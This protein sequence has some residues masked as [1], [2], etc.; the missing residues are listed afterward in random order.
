M[1][2]GK[3]QP[4]LVAWLLVLALAAAFLIPAAFGKNDGVT[5]AYEETVFGQELLTVDIVMDEDDWNSLLKNAMSEEYQ[6]AT[7]VI[8]NEKYANVGIRCKGNTSLSQVASSDSD[9]YSFKIKFDEYN[10]GETCDGLSMLVLNNLMGDATYLKEYLTYDMFHYLGADAS[11]FTMARVTVN[12]E[13][14]GVYLALEQVDEN[15]LLRE[16]GSVGELYKP[17]SM[18]FGG[19]MPDMGDF[20]MPEDFDIGNFEMPEGMEFPGM[21]GFERPS[22]EKNTDNAAAPEADGETSGD[23]KRSRGGMGGGSSLNYTDDSLDSYSTIWNGAKTETTDADHER[24]VKALKNISAGNVADYMDVDNVLRY[25]AVQTFVVNLDSLTGSMA[26]NYYLYESDGKLNLIPWDYNL[27]LGGFQSGNASETINFP[28]DTPFTSSM[29][30]RQFFAA[31]LENETYLAQYHENL[32][33]LCE[34]YASTVFPQTYAAMRLLL[35]DLVASEEAD[36]T[37]FYTNEEY[38]EAVEML[39]TTI[40]LRAESILGQL[41]GTIP[42]TT[43]GQDAE[44]D[45]LIDCTDVNLSVMGSQFGGGRGGFEMPGKKERPE[46]MGMPESGAFPVPNEATRPDAAEPFAEQ[47]QAS[48]TAPEDAHLPTGAITPS[49]NIPAASPPTDNTDPAVG[50]AGM[51]SADIVP[52]RSENQQFENRGQMPVGAYFPGSAERESASLTT[53]LLVTGGA[54]AALVLAFIFAQLYHRRKFRTK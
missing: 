15:M 51:S 28:I 5:V 11:L 1:I 32:R 39:R 50:E 18:N 16:Y 10:V 22:S 20:E 41:D 26:H 13:P 45:K 21:G 27:A 37:A 7:V 34:E 35:D 54:L 47:N 23:T 49:L 33:V 44:P 31:L 29:E 25:M 17:D 42:S 19:G 6:N 46:N 40:E 4:G 3:K 9:R 53:N 43:D 30:D 2:T 24:V 52:Q 14:W 48:V 38:Q 8:N 36:P 12:G